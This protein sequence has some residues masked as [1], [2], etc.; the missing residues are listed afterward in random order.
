MSG[1][2]IRG[3]VLEEI[4]QVGDRVEGVVDLMSD[5]GGEASGD[6][7]LLVG[8]QGGAGAALHGDVAE[9]HDDAG[10]FAGLVADGCAAVVDGKLGA[11]LAD[12][13]GV[14]GDADDAVEPLDFGDGVLNRLAGGLVDDV[15]DFADGAIAGVGFEPSG[16]FLGDGIHQLDLALGVAGD[17]TVADGGEGGTEVLLGLE[18]LFGAAALQVEGAAE[19]CG[20]GLEAVA[21]EEADDEADDQREDDEHGKP[22]AGLPMPIGDAVDAA[23]L[24]DPDDLVE[25]GAHGVHPGPA[26]KVD[27]VVVGAAAG[28]DD[29][30]DGFAKDWCQVWCSWMN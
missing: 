6:G 10:E 11:V 26:G 14:V 20:D 5:G 13:D 3:F 25:Q 23:L 9:D 27:V 1:L 22:V 29:G 2:S 17:D 30:D 24:R 12:E 15:E 19:G 7:E 18:E 8:E 16:E 28:G 21:G 4:E